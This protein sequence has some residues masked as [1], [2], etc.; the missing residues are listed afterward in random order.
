MSRRV[1]KQKIALLSIHYV[2]YLLKVFFC[3]S[4]ILNLYLTTSQMKN[5]T[6]NLSWQTS[7][8][9]ERRDGDIRFLTRRLR[10]KLCAFSNSVSFTK[11][12][13]LY[14]FRHGRYSY[15]SPFVQDCLLGS[16]KIPLAHP[17]LRLGYRYE[18]W[19]VLRATKESNS[20]GCN[21]AYQVK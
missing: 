4:K 16:L 9:Q 2:I 7:C 3:C 10:K 21:K 8:C 14:C 20:L 13:F 6:M 12:L 18:N 5:M 19:L 1:V 11:H 15:I 17:G